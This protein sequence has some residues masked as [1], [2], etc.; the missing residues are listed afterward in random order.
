MTDEAGVPSPPMVEAADAS[1]AAAADSATTNPARR[2]SA[3][4]CG[5]LP[6]WLR[7]RYE[8]QYFFLIVMTSPIWRF[9]MCLCILLLLF[10]SAVQNLWC[11]PKYDHVFDILYTVAFGIFIIDITLRILVVPGYIG[12]HYKTIWRKFANMCCG[13]CGCCNKKKADDNDWG[14]SLQFPSFLFWCD[15]VSTAC[16]LYEISFINK[17]Q[18]EIVSQ[19]IQLERYGLPVRTTYSIIELDSCFL[20]DFHICCE[21]GLWRLTHRRFP[22]IINIFQ[23]EGQ[24]NRS[25]PMVSE[26]Y[27]LVTIGKTVRVVRFVRSSR[28]AKLVGKVNWYWPFQVL[29]PRNILKYFG[30]GNNHPN[31]DNSGGKGGHHHDKNR[32]NNEGGAS[33]SSNSGRADHKK[34]DDI[35][36]HSGVGSDHGGGGDHNR[37]SATSGNSDL[38]R[39]KSWGF[40]SLAA[41]KAQHLARDEQERYGR[42]VWGHFKKAMWTI[43]LLRNDKAEWQRQLAAT[44]IQRAWRRSKNIEIPEKEEDFAWLGVNLLRKSPSSAAAAFRKHSI[45]KHYSSMHKSAFQSSQRRIS[46]GGAIPPGAGFQGAGY[47]DGRR[48]SESQVGGAM[49]ELTGQ[50]VAVGIIVSLLLSVIFT[51]NEGDSTPNSTMIVLHSQTRY[52]DFANA[53][54]DAARNSSIP[55]LLM[56]QFADNTTRQFD[57]KGEIRRLCGTAKSLVFP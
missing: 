29:N 2:K 20:F 46:K 27:L 37:G 10:G 55:E 39:R 47:F 23:E 56:Y 24:V 30:L 16:I 33:N 45:M 52:P 51:Y 42:G 49:R 12:L 15:I 50:R 48:G 40:P 38:A 21:I 19:D 22:A 53:S 35:H 25:L 11:N 57:Y 43:G 17:R 32:T 18:Q 44:K 3:Q 54:L 7:D 41:V 34:Q 8:R 31:G 9:L 26:Y 13:C 4:C 14:R 36:S 6:E 5:C 1:A 28:V